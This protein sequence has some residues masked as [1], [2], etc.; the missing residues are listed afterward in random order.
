M[1]TAIIFDLDDTL[2][3]ER[4]FV[5]SSYREIVR[6]LAAAYGTDYHEALRVMTGAPDA[7][8]ALRLWLKSRGLTENI[9]WMVEVYRTHMP[10]ISLPESTIDALVKLRGEGCLMRVMTEGREL[11]QT[12]KITA[13]G[14]DSLMTHPPLIFEPRERGGAGKNFE[15]AAADMH[16]DRYVSVGDNPAKDFAR[17]LE[18]GWLTVAVADRG[19]NIHPQDFSKIRPHHIVADISELPG[20]LL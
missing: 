2:F 19:R 16:A 12:N 3:T 11:T 5:D 13:L 7:F 4:D 9:A 17:P 10:D 6:R 20:I 15:I 18:L 1:T 14:L 8:D